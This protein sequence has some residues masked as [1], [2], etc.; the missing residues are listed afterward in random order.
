MAAER[1]RHEEERIALQRQVESLQLELEAATA[2][3]VAAVASVPPPQSRSPAAR[4]TPGRP[5]SASR[6]S[7]VELSLA[8]KED[9]EED[10]GAAAAASQRSLDFTSSLHLDASYLQAAASDQDWLLRESRDLGRSNASLRSARDQ[11]AAPAGSPSLGRGKISERR[12]TVCPADPGAIFRGSL[13]SPLQICRPRC[14]RPRA[15]RTPPQVTGSSV[16]AA[17]RSSPSPMPTQCS[18]TRALPPR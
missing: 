8:M 6:A 7:A 2:Q 10:T 16:R 18:V 15:G 4:S 13:P 17:R 5:G 9:A 3:A 14:R 12:M 1:T 11:G